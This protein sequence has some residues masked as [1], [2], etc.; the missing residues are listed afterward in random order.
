MT[1]QC[2]Q[3]WRIEED[4]SYEPLCLDC[5]HA[6]Q[7]ATALPPIARTTDPATSHAG[8]ML[9]THTGARVTHMA[10][11]D[12]YVRAN[13]GYPRAVIAQGVGLSEYETSKRLSDLKSAGKIEPGPAVVVRSGRQQQTWY[14][15]APKAHA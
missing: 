11:I 10:M 13:P 9:T 2:V 12:A 6:Q 7:A 14:P 1:F 3:C 8:A 4:H 5:Y 15:A